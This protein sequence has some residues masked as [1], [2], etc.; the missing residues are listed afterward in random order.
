MLERL[1]LLLAGR[2][3]RLHEVVR[4]GRTRGV[5]TARIGHRLLAQRNRLFVAIQVLHAG[6]TERQVLFEHGLF[7][8]GSESLPFGSL[9]ARVEDLLR[10][11]VNG[12]FPH[13]L[14]PV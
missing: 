9:I 10:Y 5:D 8:R 12:E 11:L 14:E 1:S 7:F 6:G 3:D 2:K 4:H 13:G